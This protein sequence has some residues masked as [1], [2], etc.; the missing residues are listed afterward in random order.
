MNITV[1]GMGYVGLVTASCLAEIGHQVTCFDIDKIKIASLLRGEV[2][3]HEPGLKELIVENINKKQLTFTSQAADAYH[4]PDC[5]LITVGTPDSGTG[6]VDLSYV[7]DAIHTLTDNLQT[8][9]YIAIK[10]TVP[11]GTCEKLQNK[12]NKSLPVHLSATVVSNPEFL[13][14]GSG[15]YD[16]FHADRIVVGTNDELIKEF[17]H[18][19]YLGFHVP[20]FF[21][22]IKSAEMI[23]YAANTFLATKISFINEI[24][25]ICELSGADIEEVA[26]GIGLDKRIGSSF[27]KSG[28]G[29]GGS[30]FP[31]DTM[32][33][34]RFSDENGY[35]FEL[36]KSTIKVNERQKYWMFDKLNDIFS[37]LK[38][39]EVAVLGLSFKPFTDD[40]RGAPSL[41][42]IEQLEKSG[43]EITVYDPVASKNFIEVFPNIDVACTIEEAIKDKVVTLIIT[44]W[45]EIINFPLSKYIGL[46][47]YPIVLDGRNCYPITAVE[48]AEISY[49]SIGRRIINPVKFK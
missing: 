42:I 6:T 45:P 14:E 3:I 19:L 43:V 9:S 40:L 2:N 18:R 37:T 1:T 41:K 32:S 49:Y 5:V 26:K 12:I 34:N 46:M 30:C 48:Q 10:S 21:T 22:D 7:Y 8:C 33:F 24:A 44:E 16:T 23:K 20:L 13:R 28:I 25:N 35:S 4:N 36:L 15:I 39:L 17:F 47:K 29:Y 27:L 31:K 11:V 38:G